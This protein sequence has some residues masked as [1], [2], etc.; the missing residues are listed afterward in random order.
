MMMKA[1]DAQPRSS[2]TKVNKG[3]Q[4]RKKK[5][6]AQKQAQK[7]EAIVVYSTS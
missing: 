6:L 4:I 1:K 7:I 5:K 3:N 2:K